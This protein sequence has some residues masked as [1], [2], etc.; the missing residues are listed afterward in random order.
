MHVWTPCI[1]LV[2]AQVRRKC[3]ICWNWGD[4]CL[5][6]TMLVLGSKPGSSVRTTSGSELLSSLSSPI[7]IFFRSVQS[8]RLYYRISILTAV[9]PPSQLLFLPTPVPSHPEY[10]PFHIHKGFLNHLPCGIPLKLSSHLTCSFLVK[11]T[12]SRLELYLSR[13]FFGFHVWNMWLFLL[14][15]YEATQT[16]NVTLRRLKKRHCLGKYPKHQKWLKTHGIQF[17]F[18]FAITG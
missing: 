5:W 14:T 11:S 3:P 12:A 4:E 13:C 2:H 17:F 7:T 9:G 6:A 10:S 15:L 8:H 18:F 1:Y 16:L